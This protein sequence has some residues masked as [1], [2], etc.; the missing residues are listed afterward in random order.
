MGDKPDPLI[1]LCGFSEMRFEDSTC[2]RPTP[3]A[4]K[5]LL[6][7][8]SQSLP[9]RSQV[10]RRR[11]WSNGRCLMSPSDSCLLDFYLWILKLWAFSQPSA[12]GE[13]TAIHL[14]LVESHCEASYMNR[15]QTPRDPRGLQTKRSPM[16]MGT[17]FSDPA[18][19]WPPIRYQGKSHLWVWSKGCWDN[20]SYAKSSYHTQTYTECAGLL[21]LYQSC[22]GG[23]KAGLMLPNPQLV[24]G[25]L[26]PNDATQNALRCDLG[27]ADLEENV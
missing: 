5:H 15:S 26:G 19:S 14:P 7:R 22:A 24:C 4:K 18:V 27:A 1:G 13:S 3:H 6:I 10:L 9:Y 25:Q 20:V 8:Q 2:S 21:L 17:L 12:V 16:L 23:P 11:C